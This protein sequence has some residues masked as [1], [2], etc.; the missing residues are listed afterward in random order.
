MNINFLLI[1][2]PKY[3]FL[4]QFFKV[5]F[6]FPNELWVMSLIYPSVTEQ[7]FILWRT[8]NNTTIHLHLQVIL[9]IIARVYERVVYT[10]HYITYWVNLTWN[11]WYCDFF[12]FIF[13]IVMQNQEELFFFLKKTLACVYLINMHL[14]LSRLVLQK[15]SILTHNHK[16]IT[17]YSVTFKM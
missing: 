12:I 5:R 17:K 16:L 9:L 1:I 6:F 7:N 8:G 10:I 13:F 11:T 2:L 3:Y 14:L 15:L 4:F